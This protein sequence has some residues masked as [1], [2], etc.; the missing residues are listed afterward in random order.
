[1]ATEIERKTVRIFIRI[2]PNE[3]KIFK[4]K[5]IQSGLSMSEFI[6]QS[7]MDKK[8]VSSPPVEF[9]EMIREI[10]RV[11]SNLNQVQHKLNA[12]GIA[13]PLELKR[14][15]NRIREVIDLLYETYRPGKGEN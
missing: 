15:A 1:M 3:Y 2:T 5:S 6:R 10:K 11:G 8:I 12:M 9:S 4:E 7:A 14:C 13:H